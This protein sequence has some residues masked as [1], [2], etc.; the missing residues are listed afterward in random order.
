MLDPYFVT[1][2]ERHLALDGI[3]LQS[4]IRCIHST[5]MPTE[6]QEYAKLGLCE[7]VYTAIQKAAPN[8]RRTA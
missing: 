5:L 7:E 6:H 1:P 2:A 3:I 8:A 4:V